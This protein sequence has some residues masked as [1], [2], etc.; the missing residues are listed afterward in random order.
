MKVE[1]MTVHPG[2]LFHIEENVR[3]VQFSI[4][5]MRRGNYIAWVRPNEEDS[6][7]ISLYILPEVV[8]L[9]VEYN[10]LWIGETC[11]PTKP[12]WVRREIDEEK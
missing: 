2:T 3:V 6:L 12:V 7:S 8:S 1:L 5:E 10:T 4:D 9:E 11:I